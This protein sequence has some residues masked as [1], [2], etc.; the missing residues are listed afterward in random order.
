MPL[1][2]K[3][4]A[5]GFLHGLHQSR[6]RGVGIEF[7]QFRSYEDGDDL[8]RIDWKLF[9]RSDR[10]FVREAERESEIAVWFVLDTSASMG[11]TSEDGWSKMEYAAHLIATLSYIAYRQGDRIGFLALSSDKQ[12]IIPLGNGQ[13][14]WMSI[15]KTLALLQPG[16]P[17]PSPQKVA[18]LLKPLQ[19]PG[20]IF[21]I[22]DFYQNDDEIYA[23]ARSL[24]SPK[25]DLNAI[26]V[27]ND[28]EENF[29]FKGII[30]FE[31]A[32]SREQ[33][34]VSGSEARNIYLKAKTE[35]QE[36]LERWCGE[37]SIAY[38][39]VNVDSPL[40]QSVFDFLKTRERGAR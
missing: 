11:V 8:S 35:F 21:L 34:L 26:H 13:Q 30:R 25:T 29:P 38:T 18:H 1:I 14:H 20:L 40:D 7:S 36:D 5:D 2:A 32:E 31:D 12:Q 6:Q 28:E 22:S 37:Q 4:V 23:F 9:A 15:L 33:I 39:S 27:T 24:T 17:F 19:V 10:Y 16:S 3:T